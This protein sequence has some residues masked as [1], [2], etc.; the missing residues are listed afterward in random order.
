MPPHIGVCSG[1]MLSISA[2]G[3]WGHPALSGPDGTDGRD[4][5]HE[6]YVD[7]GGISRVLAPLNTLVGVFLTDDPP[8]P[9]VTPA[10]LD[11]YLGDDMTT[12]ELQQAF[13]IGSSLEFITVPAGAT[14]LFF[15]LNDGYEWINNVGSLE[16]TVTTIVDIDIKPG[17][18]PNAINK[19][20]KGVIPVAILGSECF[21][22]TQIDL[23]TLSFEGLEVRLKGNGQPQ[24][25]YEDVSGDFTTPEGA[26]DGY[27]DLVCQFVD[28]TSS[29]MVGDGEAT[30]TGL[31]LNGT[32]FEGTDSTKVVQ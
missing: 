30:L 14:R 24:C 16:V 21:D 2:E 18:F 19:N 23:G 6:E 26:P 11:L 3:I 25:S 5:T 8:N 29:W 20:G 28:D 12:P 15:G 7:L 13:A 27:V 9:G 22:V 32:P 31:L 4:D 10:S 17:S 1:G